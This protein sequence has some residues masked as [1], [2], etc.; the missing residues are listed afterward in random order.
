[1]VPAVGLQY[2]RTTPCSLARSICTPPCYSQKMAS[3]RSLMSSLATSPGSLSLSNAD[4]SHWHLQKL[5]KVSLQ[6]WTR[7][8][9][10]LSVPFT[11][12]RVRKRP[13]QRQE[14]GRFGG[15]NGRFGGPNGCFGLRNGRFGFRKGTKKNG[16]EKECKSHAKVK[17]LSGNLAMQSVAIMRNVI[18]ELCVVG[19]ALQTF[20]TERHTCK[21]LYPMGMD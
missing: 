2:S 21:D 17:V 20:A 1:M 4:C 16:Y 12:T 15:R 3:E 14:N 5:R 6:S 9:Q 13:F 8:M 10:K 19:L 11:G 7:S 18:A